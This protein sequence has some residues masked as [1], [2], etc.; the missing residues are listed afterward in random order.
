MYWSQKETDHMLLNFW[1]ISHSLRQWTQ[2]A[3]ARFI[4]PRNIWELH[5][6]VSN[7]QEILTK[8]PL[9]TKSNNKEQNEPINLTA[10]SRYLHW[11]EN[12]RLLNRRRLWCKSRSFQRAVNIF[13]SACKNV[14]RTNYWI[15]MNGMLKIWRIRT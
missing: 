12:Q 15:T 7:A 11:I 9:N 5:S 13:P 8:D 1:D 10:W 6:S 3:K 2:Q 4:L 14:W